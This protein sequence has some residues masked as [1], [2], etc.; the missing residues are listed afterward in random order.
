MKY[1]LTILVSLA[2][3]ASSLQHSH[4]KIKNQ[5]KDAASAD[6][7]SHLTSRR[8]T[9]EPPCPNATDIAPCVC[10]QDLIDRLILECYEIE[11]EE[12][13]ETIFQQNFPVK[14]FYNLF[15]D[16]SPFLRTL[17]GSVFNG[18]SFVVVELYR[19]GIEVINEYALAD[20]LETL[21][22]LYI[23]ESLVHE[24]TFPF[25]TF[26]SYSKLTVLNVFTSELTGIPSLSSSS[27]ENIGITDAAITEIDA[28]TFQGLPSVTNI[29]LEKNEIEV[30]EAGAFTGLPTLKSINLSENKLTTLEAGTFEITDNAVSIYV[31][32]NEITFIEPG[33]FVLPP[34][35]ESLTVFLDLGSNQLPILDEVVFAEVFPVLDFLFI[36]GNPLECGCDI[37]W[38]VL[39]RDWMGKIG[40]T[41]E[42][43][44]GVRLVDLDPAEFEA[45]C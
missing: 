21:E 11:S 24:S 2:L 32:N 25:F 13:L 27:V 12:Q 31:W 43:V 4:P 15:L 36:A 41:A 45:N 34:T 19:S 17:G 28:G 7:Y 1:L 33:T 6:G 10:Y 35:N 44:D 40:N 37:A 9:R 16:M 30:L 42:C 20:S 14:E 3:V 8:E 38:L 39:N 23:K 22:S 29:N 26:S 5:P 18:V